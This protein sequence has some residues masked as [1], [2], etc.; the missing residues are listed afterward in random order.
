MFSLPYSDINILCFRDAKLE[1]IDAHVTNGL[2]GEVFQ[3]YNLE[4][5]RCMLCSEDS[6]CSLV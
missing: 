2:N 4:I 3:N 5:S 6:M 1:A